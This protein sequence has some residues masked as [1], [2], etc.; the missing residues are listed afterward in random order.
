MLSAASSGNDIIGSK[1]ALM[2]QLAKLPALHRIA[3][4]EDQELDAQHLIATLNL[5]LGRDVSI[6]HYR[7]MPAAL[8]GM[9]RVKP[10]LIFLDDHLP[11]LDHAESSMRSLARFSIDAPVVIF[12]GELTRRRRIELMR[13]EPLALIDKDDIDTLAIGNILLRLLPKAE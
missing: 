9:R 6:A 2:R 3:I 11:P 10:D 13:L 8:A 12:S 5:L 4:I 1:S 7:N